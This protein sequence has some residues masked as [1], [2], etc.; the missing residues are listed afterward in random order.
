MLTVIN[1]HLLQLF[2]AAVLSRPAVAGSP[3][4]SI[5][6]WLFDLTLFASTCW[7]YIRP[8]ELEFVTIDRIA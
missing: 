5:V 3:C 8:L 2:K 6:F 7:M 4:F 1:M